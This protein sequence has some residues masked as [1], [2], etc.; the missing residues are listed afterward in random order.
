MCGIAGI[1]SSSRHSDPARREAVIAMRDRMAHRGPDGTGLLERPGCVLGHRRLAVVDLSAEAAQ[2][3]VSSDGRFA[4]VYNGEL[5][6]DADLR[7]ELARM[8]VTFRTTGTVSI[9]LDPFGFW[10]PSEFHLGADCSGVSL[11]P[12]DMAVRVT[13]DTADIQGYCPFVAGTDTGL[14]IG[15]QDGR[16]E[17]RLSSGEWNRGNVVVQSSAPLT[18]TELL[19]VRLLSVDEERQFNR[20][21]LFIRKDGAYVDEGWTRGIQELTTCTSIA[22]GD[23]DNDMDLDLYLGCTGGVVNTAN[24]VLENVGGGRFI[25]REDAAAGVPDGRTGEVAAADFDGD[26]HRDVVARRFDGSVR[27]LSGPFSDTTM[28]ASTV[29]LLGEA[30]DA[31]S[32]ACGRP[33]ASCP[34]D[35]AST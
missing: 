22:S 32:G 23:F 17:I 2:P 35:G 25:R 6:N 11:A 34:R 5:Y 21:R 10:D 15:V 4:I 14:F 31:S 28:Q 1:L 30:W 29:T 9:S 8:G 7:A 20:D 16:F 13:A 27:V 19:D 26:G 12:D 18:D 33:G 3:M 24:V